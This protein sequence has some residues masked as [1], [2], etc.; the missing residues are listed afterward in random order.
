MTGR[1][2]MTALAADFDDDGWVDIYV[3]SD[4]TSAILCHNNHDGTFTDVVPSG[5]GLSENGM[6]QAGMGVASATSTRTAAS[7]CSRRTSRTTSA[8]YRSTAPDSSR[9][10][11]AAGLGVENRFI[12]WER[13]SPTSTTTGGRT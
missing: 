2:S 1:Y 3:A 9:M 12:E 5:A 6:P 7:I 13:P 10:R 4:S 8:L 11:S